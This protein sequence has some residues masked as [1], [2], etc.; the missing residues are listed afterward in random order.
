[1]ALQQTQKSSFFWRFDLATEKEVMDIIAK[2]KNAASAAGHDEIFFI[3]GSV[4]HWLIIISEPQETGVIS[5]EHKVDRVVLLPEAWSFDV[6]FTHFFR[7]SALMWSF[8]LP[9][10]KSCSNKTLKEF[11]HLISQWKLWCLLLSLDPILKTVWCI[12]KDGWN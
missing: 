4:S 10:F 11:Y 3:S 6:I 8:V 2:M 7:W 12:V 9:C 1:M 5:K